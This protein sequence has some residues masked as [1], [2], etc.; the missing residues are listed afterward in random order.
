MN[1]WTHNRH[2]L[3]IDEFEPEFYSLIFRYF[4]FIKENNVCA[5]KHKQTCLYSLYK[6]CITMK[7]NVAAGLYGKCVVWFSDCRLQLCYWKRFQIY[8]C[9]F[10]KC[11]NMWY[12]YLWTFLDPLL[13]HRR[14]FRCEIFCP[15]QSKKIKHLK[16]ENP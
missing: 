12:L 3:L 13:H 10:C 1:W 11:A 15:Y 4:F 8:K 9:I 16:R 7:S 6:I 2:E 5:K 14:H